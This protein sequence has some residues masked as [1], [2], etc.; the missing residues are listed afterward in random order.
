MST[1]QYNQIDSPID[2]IIVQIIIVDNTP[3]RY[4]LQPE[5]GYK[6]L[7]NYSKSNDLTD[8]SYILYS[9]TCELDYDFENNTRGFHAIKLPDIVLPEII[10]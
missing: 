2:N 7:D 5:L 8:N 6:L 9:T 3:V 4:R 10:L 1:I